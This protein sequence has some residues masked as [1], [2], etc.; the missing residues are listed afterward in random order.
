MKKR[1]RKSEAPLLSGLIP[2]AGK[3]PAEVI[4]SDPRY[5]QFVATVPD[6]LFWSSLGFFIAALLLNPFQE[7]SRLREWWQRATKVFEVKKVHVGRWT[8]DFVDMMPDTDCGV[9]VHLKFKKTL[10]PARLRLRIIEMSGSRRPVERIIDLS[11]PEIIAGETLH[12]PVVTAGSPSPGWDHTR[13]RGWGPNAEGSLIGGSPNLVV[14]ECERGFVTQRHRLYVQ[15]TQQVSNGKPSPC[16][17]VLDESHS[18][19][20]PEQPIGEHAYDGL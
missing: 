14:I 5:L 8:D 2:I 6:W 12:I 1:L 3:I 9:R 11:R 4:S 10:R 18:P 13:P 16:I 20:D 7:D 15:S 19:F 17:F